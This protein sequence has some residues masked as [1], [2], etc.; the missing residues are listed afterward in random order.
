MRV[1]SRRKRTQF[2]EDVA[3]SLNESPR[4]LPSQYL[5]DALGSALFEAICQLPWYRVT[6][7]ETALLETHAAA[8][9]AACQPLTEIVELGPGSGDKLA[10][11]LSARATDSGLLRIHLIDVS[12]AAL[13]D[14][15][16][17]LGR[18]PELLVSRH[19]TTYESGLA[20]LARDP[21]PA[22]RRL[23]LLLGSNI[24][25]FDETQSKALLRRVHDSLRPGDT[26]LLG[27][28]LI[29]PE[30]ELVLAYDD[31]LGVTAAFTRNVLLRVNR[32]LEG[33]FELAAF[34]YRAVWNPDASRVEAHL[35]SN[36]RQTVRIASSQSGIEPA[37]WRSHLDRKRLQ[38]HPRIALRVAQSGRVRSSRRL[39]GR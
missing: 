30:R 19:H 21:A 1:C 12:R 36:R 24:G 32:E 28:D 7:A 29:K 31:P 23:A 37:A 34:D 27:A 17:R 9:L 3:S 20:R 38:V 8:I 13:R 6:R 2:A 5:Y 4:R 26:F 39:D 22:G 11:L 25:N 16:R 35:V 33:D 18:I 10:R 14:A 15:A